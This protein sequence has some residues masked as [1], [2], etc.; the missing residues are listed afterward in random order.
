MKRNLT[1]IMLLAGIL[2]IGTTSASAAVGPGFYWGTIWGG[3]SINMGEYTLQT[4]NGNL[5]VTIWP[6]G[7]WKLQDVHIAIVTNPNDFPLNKGGNP[8]L[9]EFG[10]KASMTPTSQPFRITIDLDD[11]APGLMAGDTVYVMI[12]TAMMIMDSAGMV[13]QDET[14][15]GLACSHEWTPGEPFPAG[16]Y[17]LGSARWAWY[18]A[19]IL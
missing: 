17:K 10:W 13:I 3:Q 1:L 8:K 12:H 14:G 18:F 16:F 6:L 5:E 19:F 15:W 11:I 4:M 7:D 9:N 2:L